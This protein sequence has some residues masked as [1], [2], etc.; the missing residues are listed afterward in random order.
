[1]TYKYNIK[2][3][4]KL[5]LPYVIVAVVLVGAF[6]TFFFL[7]RLYAFLLSAIAVWFSSKILKSM[8]N[9]V[10]SRIETFTEGFNVFLADGTK[11]EF[12]YDL[13]THAGLITNTNFVFAYE[14]SVDS[15]VQLP[16]YFVNFPDFVEELKENVSCYKDYTL[17]EGQTIIDWL[18][19]ELGITNDDEE[20]SES[21]EIDEKN[22][23]E[24]EKKDD[25]ALSLESSLSLES[26]ENSEER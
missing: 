15:I 8:K 26:Q 16:P 12:Q 6:S 9:L 2:S 25:D 3:N 5:L 13:I 20:S 14:E 4:I 17:E 21:E 10:S 11:L 22:D 18:K 1:M 7:S 24:I 23:I 19:I